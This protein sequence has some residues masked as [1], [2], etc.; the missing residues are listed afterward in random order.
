MVPG[1]QHCGAGPGTDVFGNSNAQVPADPSSNMQLSLEQWTEK[2]IAPSTI[3]ARK[4]SG[5]GTDNHTIMTRPL[6]VYP[7]ASKYKGSG[8]PND[9]ANFACAAEK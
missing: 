4:L 7:Q 6:C 1:M 2:G 3:L 5:P 9:A 8:D